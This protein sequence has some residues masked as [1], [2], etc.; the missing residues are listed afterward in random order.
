MALVE[1]PNR[2]GNYF[3]LPFINQTSVQANATGEG[4]VFIG[5]CFLSSGSGTSK[6]LSSAGGKIHWSTSQA[7]IFADATSRFRVGV[8]DVDANGFG[9]GTFDV[10]QEYVGGTDPIANG[11][12]TATM[13]SGTKTIADGDEIAVA[14][15]MTVRGGADD[16]RITVNTFFTIAA[17]SGYPYNANNNSAKSQNVPSFIIEFDDGTFGYFYDFTGVYSISTTA[18]N[19]GTTPDEYGL[20]FQVPYKCSSRILTAI[21]DDVDLGDTG[22]LILYSDPLGT[23]VAERTVNVT[24]SSAAG[25]T[26]G[27]HQLPITE[28]EF[29]INTDYCIAYRPTSAGNRGIFTMGMPNANS[30]ISLMGGTT[31]RG[32]TRTDQTGAFTPNTTELYGCGMLI[33]KYDDGAGGGGASQHSYGF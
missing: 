28:F 20:L 16:V 22:E 7:A 12:N 27:L 9:D 25:A 3:G 21:L 32:A 6:V 8:Q 13:G 4:V 23:P 24:F 2:Q 26:D 15:M 30:R 19:S 18:I 10:F 33:N 5:K 17:A 14:L 1:F 31:F 29:T 11:L